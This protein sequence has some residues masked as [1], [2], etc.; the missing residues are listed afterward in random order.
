MIQTGENGLFSYPA[1]TEEHYCFATVAKD[2]AGNQEPLPTGSGDTC[3]TYDSTPPNSQAASPDHVYEGQVEITWTAA[4]NLSGIAAVTLWIR[5]NGGSWHDTGLPIQ[6]GTNGTF[7]Y[8][9]AFGPG[10][11]EFATRG[12]DLAGN[13]EGVPVTADTLTVYKILFEA[14]IPL[15]LKE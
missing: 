2:T 3:T 5:F 14:Y 15:V 7:N 11:Y 8:T 9:F 1:V 12:V 13:D 4:D 10:T 6:T